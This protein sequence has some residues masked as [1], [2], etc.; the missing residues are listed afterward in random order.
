[1]SSIL[2]ALKKLEHE[3]VEKHSE[4]DWPDSFQFMKERG[5]RIRFKNNAMFFLLLFM[6]LFLFS[7][8]FIFYSFRDSTQAVN[9]LKK[10]KQ[11]KAALNR[12]NDTDAVQERFRLPEKNIFPDNT[13]SIQQKPPVAG[14]KPMT[15]RGLLSTKQP[16]SNNIE[17]IPAG[18]EENNQ[19]FLP[20]LKNDP[21]IELQALVWAEDSKK[22]FAVIN[23]RI[24]REGQTCDGIVVAKIN[25]DEVFFRDGREEWR[26]KFRIK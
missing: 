3:G 8:G 26:E 7:G 11:V 9:T 13:R 19:P 2:K 14:R 21:R 18:R 22:S 6:V 4:K 1:M 23:N 15:E 12:E 10:E 20:K 25:K 5:K 24:F 16:E 17:I